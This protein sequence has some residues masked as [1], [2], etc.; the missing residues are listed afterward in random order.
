[1]ATLINPYVVEN[2]NGKMTAYHKTEWIVDNSADVA[3]IP[4]VAPGSM[5]YTADM[6]YMAMYD[7]TQWKRIG[8]GS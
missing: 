1:M 3:N 2:D 7:G 5:A 6:T 4:K 8:G